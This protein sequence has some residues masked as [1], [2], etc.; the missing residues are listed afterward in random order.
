MSSLRVADAVVATTSP[1]LTVYLDGTSTPVSASSIVGQSV[2]SGQAG[3][4]LV[5]NGITPIFIRLT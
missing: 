5:A 4:A 2:A 1:A 3:F